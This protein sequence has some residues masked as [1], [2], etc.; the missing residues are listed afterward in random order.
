MDELVKW[1]GEQL[2]EDK[3]IAQATTDRQP[4]DEWGAAGDDREGETARKF[5]SVVSIA[6]M[7]QIPAARDLA[8][9]IAEHDPARVLREIEAKRQAL[10]HFE[11]IR[12]HA[13]QGDEAYVLAEGAV[14]KQIQIMAT[15]YADRPGYLEKW[16]P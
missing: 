15:A 12:Q 3:R 10:A 6:S 8:T 9:F 4:Y 2:D 11:R 7:E 16:R 13:R 5:W 1:L 14:S